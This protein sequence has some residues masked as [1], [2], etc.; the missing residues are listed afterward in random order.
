M[1]END[2]IT[3]YENNGKCFDCYHETF[4]KIEE[5]HT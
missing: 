3:N 5:F 4:N 1:K 2:R